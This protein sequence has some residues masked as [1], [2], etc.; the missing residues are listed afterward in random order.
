MQF[1]TPVFLSG[2]YLYM[3]SS[4]LL[5]VHILLIL[6]SLYLFPYELIRHEDIII[7]NRTD[8]MQFYNEKYWVFLSTYK[9]LLFYPSELLF[10]VVISVSLTYLYD[11]R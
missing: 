4:A 5:F 1:Q 8:S 3:Q 2:Q 9:L 10:F 11:K 7:K 6:T